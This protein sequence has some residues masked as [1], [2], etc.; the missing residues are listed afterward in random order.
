MTPELCVRHWQLWLRTEPRVEMQRRQGLQFESSKIQCLLSKISSHRGSMPKHR[1]STTDHSRWSENNLNVL[2]AHLLPQPPPKIQENVTFLREKN[3]KS[4]L[5]FWDIS[6]QSSF[7]PSF[8][9]GRRAWVWSGLPAFASSSSFPSHRRFICWK[10]WKFRLMLGSA[11]LRT[12]LHN[13]SEKSKHLNQRSNNGSQT[14]VVS[15]LAG[16]V[17]TQTF[18]PHPRHFDTKFACRIRSQVNLML[19]A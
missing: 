10:H 8:T 16:L 2:N 15:T 13:W 4:E 5:T 19:L 14:L 17:R 1:V 9:Q 3:R 6:T 11:S 7:P 12:Q 18:R